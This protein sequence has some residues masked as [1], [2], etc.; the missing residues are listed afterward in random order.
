MIE[1]F[2]ARGHPLEEPTNLVAWAARKERRVVVMT[3]E[4]E[5]WDILRRLGQ[6]DDKP[7][8]VAVLEDL[9]IDACIRALAEGAT[10]IVARNAEPE[11]LRQVFDE[12]LRGRSLLPAEVVAALAAKSGLRQDSP[13]SEREISWLR[14]L[15]Q[16]GTIAQLAD[17]MGYSERA[18]YRLLRDLYRRMNV[19]NR[20]EAVLRASQSGLI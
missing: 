7:V 16:G 5:G 10:T 15:S 14:A 11:Y 19:K 4:P 9:S 13:L 1:V 18:M 2:G 17:E 8:V 12:A 3:V 20:T 6:L